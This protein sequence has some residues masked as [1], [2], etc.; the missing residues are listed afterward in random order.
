[1]K[2]LSGLPSRDT[3]VKW[4]AKVLLAV[5]PRGLVKLYLGESRDKLEETSVT[6]LNLF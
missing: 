2:T 3:I 6:A 5:N 4:P 1:M